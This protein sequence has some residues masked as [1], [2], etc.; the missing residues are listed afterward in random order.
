MED[1][2]NKKLLVLDIDGTLVNS[3]K[4]ITKRTRDAIID[5]Q[6]RGHIVALASGRPYPGMEKY[7]KAIEL[8]SFGG[9]A[10]SYNGGII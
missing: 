10:L 3:K 7:A 1:T 5:I 8:D 2:K 9:Y 6:R 4:E